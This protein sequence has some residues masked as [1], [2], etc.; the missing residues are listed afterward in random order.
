[1]KIV[2]ATSLLLLWTCFLHATASDGLSQPKDIF[3]SQRL[4]MVEQQIHKRGVSDEQT[5]DAMRTVARHQ[6]VPKMYLPF[7]YADQPV[8]IGEGQTISQ[9]YIVALM[10][11]KLNLK[12]GCKALEIGTGS[13]YQAAILS[14]ICPQVYT[15]EIIPSLANQARERLKNL[16]YQNITV[17][18][19]DGYYGWEQ[20]APFD[21]IVVTAAASHI[22]PALTKQLNVGG[23]MVIPLGGVFQVQRLMVVHKNLDGSLTTENIL[24]VRFVP[25][26]GGH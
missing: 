19:A 15:I 11:E 23:N 9:P 18:I 24:P 7:A 20:Y 6:F 21:A 17:K 10:T 2:K 5:L 4:R 25:L 14:Q 1:M 26:T 22:P 12:A 3:T 13:G 16:G 8:P